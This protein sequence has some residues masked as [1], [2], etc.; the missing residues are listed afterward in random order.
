MD[1][2]T[3][4]SFLRQLSLLAT[5]H[6]ASGTSPFRKTQIRPRIISRSGIQ[7]PD[8]VFWINK[9]SFVAGGFV[10][11]VDED[12]LV[13]NDAQA[14]AHALGV[15]YFATWSSSK[16]VF[17]EAKTLTPC[18]E[19]TS[20][21]TNDDA[22]NGQKIDLF[23][24]TLIQTMNQF[25]TLAV[26]GTCP[27]QKLSYWHLTNLCLALATKAQATLSN[28]LRLKGY[29]SNPLQ[30]QSLARHK[31]NLCIARIF[32]LE[33][34]DLMPHNLQPD[35]LDHAL[36]Y[37]VNSLASEQ[38][39]HLNPTTN[40]PQLDE[41][42]AIILHHLLHRLGQVA[43]F[44]NRKRAS[45]LV[46]QLLLHSDPLGADTPTAQAINVDTSIYSNTIRTT[47]T[48]NNKFIEIDLPVRLVYKQ[49]L[50]ELLGWSKADQYSSTV[51]A[52]K[53]EP[54]ATAINGILFDTQTPETSYRNNWLTNIR[55]VWPGINFS[56]PR[57][58]PI[59]AYEF[60]YLLGACSAGSKLDLT[61]PTQLLSS[62]FSATLFKLLQDNFT[63]HNVDL[64]QNITVRINGIKAHDNTV[65]TTTKLNYA[66]S[67]VTDKKNDSKTTD[68]KDR[69]R[70]KIAYKQLIEQIAHSI[71][72]DGIPCFPDQYL[73]DFYRP[74]LVSYPNNDGHW[75]I[76]TEFMG[77]FQLNNA[78]LGAD[79]AKLTVDN[80]FL[81]FA[82]VLASYCGNEF[83][84]PKD[85]IIVTTIVTRYLNDLAKLHNT[86]WRSTHAALQ[87]NKAANRLFTKT[88]DALE[89]PPRK[90]TESIL[91][92][93]GILLQSE[94]K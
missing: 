92:R 18:N 83:K 38:F 9:D 52:I 47:K 44:E 74:Q 54:Q 88:W 57:S 55:L 87:Q 41:R 5:K 79:A 20:P 65:E 78:S 2:N 42:S 16:I 34:S 29:K 64:C 21:G 3:H 80:E 27:P 60:I 22:D 14:C 58:T 66:I 15:S 4:S 59:W 71:K 49:L 82:I 11:C 53:K 39:S 6:I 33:Y 67:T 86:I 30:L 35:N 37:C 51:F 94:R 32:V 26:L 68:K 12:S 62:P 19:I 72:S 89:L 85:T 56:L 69:S 77:S 28:H 10:L 90:Q 7:F 17:W 93:F 25:R 1:N 73:Y 43:L 31:V 63:L 24:D 23:E 61:V 45:K 46:Q 36:A 70:R 76:G 84:L 8:L 48:K 50:C 40:E 91:K 75:Q 13:L 81:A